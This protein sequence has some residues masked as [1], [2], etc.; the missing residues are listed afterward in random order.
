MS[1]T[2]FASSRFLMQ[3][4]L[5]GHRVLLETSLWILLH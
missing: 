5:E 4:N 1:E 3:L 2:L